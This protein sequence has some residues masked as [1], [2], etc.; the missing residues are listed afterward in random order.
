MG[1][2]KEK[3]FYFQNKKFTEKFVYIYAQYTSFVTVYF[4][5]S[6]YFT[7]LKFIYRLL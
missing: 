6:K 4:I 3:V 2:Y 7:V 5:D 1:K